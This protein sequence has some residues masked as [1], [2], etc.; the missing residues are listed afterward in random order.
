MDTP[1]WSTT[2]RALATTALFLSLSQGLSAAERA[3]SP[4]PT[5][6]AARHPADAGIAKDPAVVFADDFEAWAGDGA[7]PPPKT[8]SIRRNKTGRTRAIAGQITV[9]KRRGPGQRILEIACWTPG[10]GSSSAGLSRKLGNY[11]HAREGLGDGHDELYIRYYIRFDD[12]YEAVANHGANLGGRDV[13]RGGSAWVGMA[14]I[15]NVA[16]RGYFYSGVQPRGKLG[17]RV[18]EM[19]FYSYHLDKRG[20]WGENYPVQ[21]PIPIGVGTWHCIERHMKLNSVDP[22]KPDP[23][24]ADGIEE[25]WVDGRLSIRKEGVRF[26]RVP[27]LRITFFSLETYY[28][29]LPAKYTRESPIKVAI[30][31]L[32]IARSPIGPMVA[33]RSAP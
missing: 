11:N 6:I 10:K 27:Q 26:R 25:L 16:S 18:L 9:G 17:T 22:S 30:D 20:P 19:G 24:A 33:G 7:E 15:R 3:A 1:G 8:W 29:R 14:G 21:Q 32:V 4:P 5:G 31:N 2:V 13:T 23:A 12:A 28:H